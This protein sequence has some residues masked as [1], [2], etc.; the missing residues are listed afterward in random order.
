[1]S[2]RSMDDRQ[3][4]RSPGRLQCA[5]YPSSPTPIVCPIPGTQV[6]PQPEIVKETQPKDEGTTA[7]RPDLHAGC[8]GI[9]LGAT[10]G[11][12]ERTIDTKAYRTV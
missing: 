6:R 11:I 9:K 12:D 10:V 7:T 1:M 5:T 4:V 2:P 8:P 3:L